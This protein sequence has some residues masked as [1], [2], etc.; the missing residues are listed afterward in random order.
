MKRPQHK[1]TAGT[2]RPLERGI[3]VLALDFLRMLL[4]HVVL[5][6]IDMSLGGAPAVRGKLRDAQGLQELL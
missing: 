3:D 6:G 1:K 2:F 4:A 5:L